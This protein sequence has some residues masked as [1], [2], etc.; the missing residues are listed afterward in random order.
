MDGAF[1]NPPE[2]NLLFFFRRGFP[3]KQKAAPWF[4]AAFA[5]VSESDLT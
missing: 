5:C 3:E 2:E 4:G 1:G